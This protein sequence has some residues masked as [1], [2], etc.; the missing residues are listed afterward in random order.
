MSIVPFDR[1]SSPK[2]EE[3]FLNSPLARY[4][5]GCICIPYCMTEP[6]DPSDPC[7]DAKHDAWKAGIDAAAVALGG[8]PACD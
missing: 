7:F 4:C 5:S 8:R 2:D 1:H 6:L 3:P